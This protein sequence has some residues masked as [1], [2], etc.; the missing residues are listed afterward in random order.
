M[1]TS[2]AWAPVWL[3]PAGLCLDFVGVLLLGFDL[4]RVQRSMKR[5]AGEDLKRF[6]AMVEDHGGTDEWIA[7][8]RSGKRWFDEHNLPAYDED[9]PFGQGG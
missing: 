2:T 8:S 5:Q 7:F 1:C 6:D 4:V 3:N 9:E